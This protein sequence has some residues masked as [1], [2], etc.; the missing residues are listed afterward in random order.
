[1]PCSGCTVLKN[2]K[3]LRLLS[4]PSVACGSYGLLSKPQVKL[5]IR[6]QKAK[7]NQKNNGVIINL[8]KSFGTTQRVMRC[9]W[10]LNLYLQAAGTLNAFNFWPSDDPRFFLI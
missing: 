8:L 6:N 3:A 5:L 9:P 1:M 2:V 4:N 10:T 7:F